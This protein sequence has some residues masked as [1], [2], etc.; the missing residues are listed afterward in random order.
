[1]FSKKYLDENY[2]CAEYLSKYESG[3]YDDEACL[4]LV[5]PLCEVTIDAEH[6]HLVIG[7]AGADGIEFCYR[8]DK[9]GVWAYYPIEV[10]FQK[11]AANIGQLIEGWHNGA[12]KI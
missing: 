4:H 2:H 12:I 6:Q 9:P 7:H 3:Y 8:I 11:V 5:L 10:K 1:M